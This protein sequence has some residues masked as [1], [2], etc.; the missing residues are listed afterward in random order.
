MKD[1]I[2]RLLKKTGETGPIRKRLLPHL[3]KR[4]MGKQTTPK[5]RRIL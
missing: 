4:H 5:T 3:E 1:R 2:L